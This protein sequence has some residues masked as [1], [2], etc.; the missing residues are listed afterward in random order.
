MGGIDGEGDVTDGYGLI[1][2]VH[3]LDGLGGK[4]GRGESGGNGEEGF[5]FHLVLFFVKIR[6]P[7]N[8]A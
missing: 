1:L 6:I 3:Q 4:G 2:I 7:K 8:N 5:Q